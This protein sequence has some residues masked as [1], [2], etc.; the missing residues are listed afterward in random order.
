M[1][2]GLS[3]LA[4]LRA[5]VSTPQFGL[6]STAFF[7]CLYTWPFLTMDRPAA[8]FG[9]TFAL[10]AVHIVLIAL[11]GYATQRTAAEAEGEER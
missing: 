3:P 8:I 5:L 2:D 11:T 1:S 4:R 7:A 10:W 9:Y 6:L